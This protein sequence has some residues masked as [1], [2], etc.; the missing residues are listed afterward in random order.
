MSD[1]IKKARAA[2]A[3]ARLVARTDPDTAASR[4]YYAMFDIARVL[5]REKSPEL[6]AAKTHATII[7]RF[8]KYVSTEDGLDPVLG[9]M[10][11]R[12]SELRHIADYADVSIAADVAQSLEQSKD[13]FMSA[14]DSRL[15]AIDEQQRLEDG[16]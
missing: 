9:R 8:A 2:A 7:R 12:A 14:L 16:E 11:N 4:A 3:T 1:L 6:A 13:V 5:L 10:L 15:R